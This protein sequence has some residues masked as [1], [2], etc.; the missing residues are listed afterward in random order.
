MGAIVK[1]LIVLKNTANV[2]GKASNVIKIAVVFSVKIFNSSG[3]LRVK[4]LDPQKKRS[5][6]NEY[7]MFS[8]VK[9][10]DI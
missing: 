1:N 3:K 5:N 9:I 6:C 10:L 2:L 7:L 8:I 4:W